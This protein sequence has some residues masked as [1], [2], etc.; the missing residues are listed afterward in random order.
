MHRAQEEKGRRRVCLSSPHTE[1]KE[2]TKLAVK[3]SVPQEVIVHGSSDALVPAGYSI[4][5]STVAVCGGCW[6]LFH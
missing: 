3:V 5:V 4:A 1:Y 6:G 2:L